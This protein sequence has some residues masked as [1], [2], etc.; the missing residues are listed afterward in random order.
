M[1]VN[2]SIRPDIRNPTQKQDIQPA[3]YPAKSVS[4]ASLLEMGDFYTEKR[5]HDH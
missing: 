5:V 2:P 4:G 1:F 3:G